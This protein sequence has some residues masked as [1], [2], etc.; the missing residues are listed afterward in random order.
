MA[1]VSG[2]DIPNLGAVVTLL[3]TKIILSSRHFVPRCSWL[4]HSIKMEGST[5]VCLQWN[6]FRTHSNTIFGTFRG[7]ADLSDVTLVCED[8]QQVEAHQIVLAASSPFFSSLFRLAKEN[9]HPLIHLTWMNLEQLESVLDFIYHGELSL[10]KDRVDA[11]L[12]LADELKLK[13]VTEKTALNELPYTKLSVSKMDSVAKKT[14][15][16]NKDVKDTIGKD[17]GIVDEKFKV[18][19]DLEEI[20]SAVKSMMST[21]ERRWDAKT[22]RHRT[23]K[24][25]VICNKEGRFGN[26]RKHIEVNHIE[27]S[28]HSNICNICGKGSTSR[29]GLGQHMTTYHK[30]VANP[31]AFE[32]REPENMNICNVCGKGS[33]SIYNLGQ[34]MFKAHAKVDS[35]H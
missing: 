8:G 15:E 31:C 18:K 9:S 6:T 27:I 16:R 1:W 19:C 17:S 13:S 33:T 5:E 4:N 23:Q 11:F 14:N 25:C 21:T 30:E 29:Y 12:T 28:G 10:Q 34:H 20:E 7:K 35:T 24:V 2:R 3:G 32:P 22:M 26:I